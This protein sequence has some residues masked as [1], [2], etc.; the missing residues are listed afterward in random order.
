MVYIILII[1]GEH[2]YI[3]VIFAHMYKDILLI[4]DSYGG[5]LLKQ[6]ESKH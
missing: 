6:L 2:Q 4:Y 3:N 5:V 1:W